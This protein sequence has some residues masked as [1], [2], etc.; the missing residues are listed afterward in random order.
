VGNRASVAAEDGELCRVMFD[1][2]SSF[3]RPVVG[4]ESLGE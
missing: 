3:N 1:G 4:S 2:S